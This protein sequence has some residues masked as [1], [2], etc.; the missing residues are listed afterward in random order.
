MF[1]YKLIIVCCKHLF[2]KI[3]KRK[4]WKISEI[5]NKFDPLWANS[6]FQPEIQIF[7]NKLLFKSL[8]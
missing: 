6:C 3:K 2:H 7:K 1:K 8:Q 5:D 4:S